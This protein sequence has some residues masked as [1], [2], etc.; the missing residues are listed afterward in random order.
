MDEEDLSD[1]EE[2]ERAEGE[3]E[4]EGDREEEVSGDGSRQLD[5]ER[6]ELSC[7]AGGGGGG[8]S[9]KGPGRGEPLSAG[10]DWVRAGSRL[11]QDGPQRQVRPTPKLKPNLMYHFIICA[12]ATGA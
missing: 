12:C 6:E 11:C 2:G 5:R 8:V 10:Q 3:E 9:D 1:V 4:E 7:C